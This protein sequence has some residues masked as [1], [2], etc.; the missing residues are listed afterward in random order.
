MSLTITPIKTPQVQIKTTTTKENLDFLERLLR[1]SQSIM[2]K[3]SDALNKVMKGKESTLNTEENVKQ[4]QDIFQNLIKL[5]LGLD[6]LEINMELLKRKLNIADLD[7]YEMVNDIHSDNDFE[8]NVKIDPAMF[9]PKTELKIKEE[10][11]KVNPKKKAKVKVKVK[12]KP[13][14]DVKSELPDTSLTEEDEQEQQDEEMFIC[15]TCGA[16]FEQ[17]QKLMSHKEDCQSR[18]KLKCHSCNFTSISLS[19]IKK[20]MRSY[21]ELVEVLF[22]TQLENE[23]RLLRAAF[24]I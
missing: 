13:D 7:Y 11:V 20:H 21:H 17:E 23:V 10:K 12:V 1:Q 5:K 18:G 15:D 16:F 8:D 2:I 9:R 22:V 19:E 6:G 24:I 3:A 14:F 4:I